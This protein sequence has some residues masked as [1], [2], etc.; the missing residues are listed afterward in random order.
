MNLKSKLPYVG[1]HIFSHM[2]A[3]ANEFGAVN[4]SQGF[5][6]FNPDPKLLAYVDECVKG[7]ANQY[8]PMPGLP[9]L[10]N[11]IS[12]NIAEIYG[13]TADADL[14]ITVGSGATEMIFSAIAATIWPGDEVILIEPCY[15]CYRPAIDVVGGTVVAYSMPAPG[16]KV[17]WS[18]FRKLVTPKTRMICICTPNNPTGTILDHADMLELCAIVTG[19]DILILSDEVYGLMVF[20]GRKPLSPMKYPELRNRTFS[21]FSFGKS[22]HVTGW[23]VGYCIAPPQLSAELRKVHQNAVYCVAHPLQKAIAMYMEN[24]HSY[25]ELPSLFER[26]RNLLLE[27]TAQS[28]L[29]PLRCEG[30]YFQLFDYSGVSDRDDLDFCERLVKEQGVAAIPVS[31]LYSSPKDH[32]L[33]RL[34]FAKEDS[35]L[36]EAG[37][38][39]SAL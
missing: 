26:K 36:V 25:L 24:S 29:K 20:D 9:Q 35:T 10:R 38:R 31:Y 4:L 33:I 8:A 19:T 1:R 11:A 32:K 12:K 18:E 14:E 28:R 37:K 23:K 2:T 6:D 15:D 34:C 16:F 5:P 3:L 27:V 17:D 30:A 13:V 7:G 21:C 39:L 22:Y